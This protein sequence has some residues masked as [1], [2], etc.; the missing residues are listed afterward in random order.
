MFEVIDENLRLGCCSI[1]DLTAQQ[2][3]SFLSGWE[4][5]AK[6]GDLT[7]FYDD[8][9]NMVVLNKDHKNYDDYLPMAKAYM[10]LNDEHRE[11]VRDKAQDSTKETLEVLEHSVMR[12]RCETIL[13][14]IHKHG[15]FDD[16]TYKV[17]KYIW[18]H[19][20]SE[21]IK[22]NSIFQYGRM[23]GK[24]EERARRKRTAAIPA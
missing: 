2:V 24:R 19:E 3:H 7:L 5:G 21:F 12:L 1:S 17:L 9:R 22:I 10:V 23:Y 16:E 6:I 4:E 14:Q 11:E 15:F 8:R 20:E 13:K 18:Y